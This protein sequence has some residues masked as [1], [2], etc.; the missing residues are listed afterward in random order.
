VYFMVA[1][2]LAQSIPT[3]EMELYLSRQQNRQ[4]IGIP[5]RQEGPFPTLLDAICRQQLRTFATICQAASVRFRL[6]AIRQ[7]LL[8]WLSHNMH[9]S[10]QSKESLCSSRHWSPHR[11]CLRRSQ[12]H[13]RKAPQRRVI[14]AQVL[15][16]SLGERLDHQQPMVER[17]LAP[18]V[19][20][21]ILLA[22]LLAKFAQLHCRRPL[23]QLRLVAVA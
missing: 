3:T 21:R 23:P 6:I 20:W 15:Q 22:E 12:S 11:R 19:H 13:R 2:M 14:A 17:K 5:L 8:A 18:C 10:S 4:E 7:M 16:N 1:G 9:F